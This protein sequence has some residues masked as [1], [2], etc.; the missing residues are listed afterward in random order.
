MDSHFKTVKCFARLEGNPLHSITIFTKNQKFPL[1]LLSFRPDP[2]KFLQ[3]NK[4]YECSAVYTDSRLTLLVVSD[5]KFYKI[6]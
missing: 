3:Q 5:I 6:R 2:K 4:T 1:D